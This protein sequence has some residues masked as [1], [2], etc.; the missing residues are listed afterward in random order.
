MVV[1]YTTKRKQ[2]NAYTAITEDD[3]RRN[4]VSFGEFMRLECVCY[5]ST[6]FARGLHC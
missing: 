5:V 2:T 4:L 6:T 1:A 3:S